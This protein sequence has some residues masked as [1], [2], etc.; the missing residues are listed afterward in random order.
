MSS[1]KQEFGTIKE[2]LYSVMTKHPETRSDD[3]LLYVK[4][5]EEMGA[6]N[7]S[8]L[9]KMGISIISVH[10]MR[11]VI[12]NKEKK[13]LPMQSVVHGRKLRN[14]EVRSFLNEERERRVNF[15]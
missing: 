13:F 4:C 14:G 8:D 15:A 12:Q 5:C 3:T 1:V 7:L 11:Q 9:P 10:K 2:M 6:K